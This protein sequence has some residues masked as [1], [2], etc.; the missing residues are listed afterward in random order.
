M[1]NIEEPDEYL[2]EDYADKVKHICQWCYNKELTGGFERYC[3]VGNICP[4]CSS[5]INEGMRRN[6]GRAVK[7]INALLY[8]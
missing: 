8:G 3:K 1:R 6:K 4:N 5:R 2:E 7:I